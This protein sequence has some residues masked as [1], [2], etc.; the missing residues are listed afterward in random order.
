MVTIC[1]T[2]HLYLLGVLIVPVGHVVDVQSVVLQVEPRVRPTAP[3]LYRKYFN[4]K[5]EINFSRQ[6]T[7]MV[8]MV[9][10]EDFH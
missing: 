2:D 5:V 10:K 7:M 8:S 1:L 9:R 6:L 4:Q 3:Q